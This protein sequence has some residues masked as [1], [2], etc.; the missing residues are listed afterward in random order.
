[1]KRVCFALIILTAGLSSCNLNAPPTDKLPT[2]LD[3]AN[4]FRDTVVE[5]KEFKGLYCKHPAHFRTCD[6]AAAFIVKNSEKLDSAYDKLLPNAYPGQAIAVDLIAVF[7]P[8]DPHGIVLSGINSAEQQNH[9]NNCLFSEF[10]IF[11]TEPF[12]TIQISKE[13]NLIDFYDPMAQATTHFAYAEPKIKAGITY[14][15]A[16]NGKNTIS[17][18]IRKEKCNGA[19]DPQYDYSAE[20]TLNGKSY[21]GCANS[22]YKVTVTDAIR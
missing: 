5:I 9:K 16:T 4:V 14:Y 1:M 18:Q 13:G 19:I 2:R 15:D 17:I 8:A 3:S 21:H 12:W 20:V 11:G 6:S 10:W 7:D 22:Y